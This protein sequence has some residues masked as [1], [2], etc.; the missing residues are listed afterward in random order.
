MTSITTWL[1]LEIILNEIIQAEKDN[2]IKNDPKN[3][4][5]QKQTQRF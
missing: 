2:L 4:A 1:D 5:E 3:L